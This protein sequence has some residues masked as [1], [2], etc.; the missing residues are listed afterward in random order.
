MKRKL[1]LLTLLSIFVLGMILTPVTASHTYTT[2]K[3]TGKLSDA[4]YNKLVNAKKKNKY[5]CVTVKTKHYKIIKIP[6]YKTVKKGQWIHKHVLKS[7]T[8]YKNKNYDSTEY[9]YST[10]KYDKNWKWYGSFFKDKEY[11]WGSISKYYWKYKKRAT[12]KVKIKIGYKKVKK[13]VYMDIYTAV[14]YEN[15]TIDFF[16]SSG[17]TASQV[18]P[19]REVRSI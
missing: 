14:N 15:Y 7:K 19:S 8:V 18:A 17:D 2:G 9:E 12:K 3:Y 16:F 1:L 5:S 10:K 4:Q 11:T 6:K 13:P